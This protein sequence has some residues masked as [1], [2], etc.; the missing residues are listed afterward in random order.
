MIKLR[1]D[2]ITLDRTILIVK[3]TIIDGAVELARSV[4]IQQPASLPQLK[5][6]GLAL[7]TVYKAELAAA[8]QAARLKIYVGRE[9]TEAQLA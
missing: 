9:F 1:I 5:E 2:R 3:C 4:E 6:S 8:A 7:I